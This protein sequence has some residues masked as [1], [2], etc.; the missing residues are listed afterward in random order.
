MG[1]LLRWELKKLTVSGLD[2]P[3]V[4]KGSVIDKIGRAGNWLEGITLD[5]NRGCR[6]SFEVGRR[7]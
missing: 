5:F 4:E 3:N 6:G 1:S 2:R 7:G